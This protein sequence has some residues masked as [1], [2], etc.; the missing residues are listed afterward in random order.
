M[1]SR[2]QTIKLV[3]EPTEVGRTP[4]SAAGPLASQLLRSQQLRRRRLS[5]AACRNVGQAILAAAG[6][7]PAAVKCRIARKSRL[8]GGC[9][10]DCLPH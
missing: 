5:F 1:T 9:R 2:T 6:F 8:K 7:Q 10:Q 3:A 4:W